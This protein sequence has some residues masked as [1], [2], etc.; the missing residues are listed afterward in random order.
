VK[1][2]AKAVVVENKWAEMNPSFLKALPV[3]KLVV[4]DSVRALGE[5]ARNHRRMF[6][7]PVLA[8]G[9]SNGKTTTKEMIRALLETKFDVLATEGNLNNHI[10]VPLTLFRLEHRHKIA[11]VEI[12]TNHPGEIGHLCSIL[13]PT[14]G[15]I[16]NIGREHL[17][18]FHSV[19]GVANAEL[20]LFEWLK[21]N[22]GENGFV[23]LNKDDPSLSRRS[24][25]L[26]HTVSFGFS[27]RE[28][29]VRGTDL[30]V[31]ENGAPRFTIVAEKKSPL[32]V[33]L[34]VPGIHNALN[35]LA[36][37]TVGLSF[38]IPAAKI[39]H[40]LATFTAASKRM[41]TVSVNGITLLNDTYNSNPDSVRAALETLG[42]IKTS[43]KK[44]AVLA[45]ML[46]LGEIS[47]REH[48]LV[49]ALVKSSGVEY[50]LTFGPLSKATHDASTVQFKAHYDQKN[51]LS[52]Y[53]A[54]LLTTG[55]TVLIKGSR[56]MKMEDVVTFL[57]ER[58]SKAA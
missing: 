8:V 25:M 18:F 52:E 40:A 32:A 58:F 9:G 20:E 15:L 19:K 22:R 35:A 10:G 33:S 23:F 37:A 57:K 12:G 43:G 28:V 47:E 7:I 44:I 45:D 1:L 55:D 4:D 46:E 56:G 30:Q 29:D 31:N 53:L 6:K 16:T 54:E 21:A 38:N 48:R 34:P 39:Q 27:R 26:R 5:L 50:L 14:H 2:G 51:I 17:E 13:E 36:A 3:A 11:V 41:E 49:A 42:A 24:R